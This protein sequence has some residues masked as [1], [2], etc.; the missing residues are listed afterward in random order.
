MKSSPAHFSPLARFFHWLMA[1]LV[2]AMLFVGVGMVSTVS[3]RH[4]TLLALHRPLG[5]A[6]LVL[7]VLRLIVRIT[8]R[9][10]P[11]PE[12]T[13]LWQ[14]R[15]AKMSHGL[16][17][18]LLLAMPLVGWSMLSAGGFPVHLFGDVNLP[19]LVAQD[20]RLYAFLRETHT[21]LAIVLFVTFIVH[22]AA[23]MFHALILRDGVF[24]SMVCGSDTAQ[25]GQSVQSR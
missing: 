24:S 22:F 18:L 6:I 21:W 9:T 13:P 12:E 14:R 20:P 25:R 11:L 19:P 23:A 2:I 10:P 16:F 17:Y 7:V 4:L 1:P 3:Q 8:H 5:I 15:A